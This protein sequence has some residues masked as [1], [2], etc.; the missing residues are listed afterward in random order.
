LKNERLRTTLC[1]LPSRVGGGALPTIE[2][3]SCCV[4]TAIQ[5]LSANAIDKAF[6]AHD[7]PIIGRIENDLYIIDPRTV[8]EDEAELIVRAFER[9][10]EMTAT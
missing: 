10:L 5:G 8:L 9:L 3:P 2:L 6:R 1:D 7:P 4:G